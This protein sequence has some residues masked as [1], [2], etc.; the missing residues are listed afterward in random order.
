[1]APVTLSSRCGSAVFRSNALSTMRMLFV[2]VGAVELQ[3]AVA[4]RAT[5]AR[6]ARAGDLLNMRA[7]A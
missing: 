6:L 4:T 3:P 5:M 1:M 7:L 2:V